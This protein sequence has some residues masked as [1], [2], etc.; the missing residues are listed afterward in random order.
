MWARVTAFF[1]R[2][3]FVLTRQRLDDE[4]RAEF[5]AHLALLKDRYIRAGMTPEEARAAARRQFGNTTL[6][7]EDVYRINTV[8]WIDRSADLFLGELRHA[9]RNL[10]RAPRFQPRPL[11]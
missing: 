8:A 4:A 11:V 9:V 3:G 10:K 7:R 2:L 1:S 6:M 5:E